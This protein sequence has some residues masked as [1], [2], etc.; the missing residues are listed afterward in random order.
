MI[1][2]ICL[3][4]INRK[5]YLANFNLS[6][7]YFGGGTPSLLTE[8]ELL[9]IIGTIR[10]NYLI[11]DDVE[12]TLESNPDDISDDNLSIWKSVGINRLSIGLQSFRSVD[13]EWMN[14]AHNVEEALVCVEKAQHAG[15]NNLTVDLIY[16]LPNLSLVEWGN[17]VQKVIDMG[18]PHLSAYCLTV[19]DKTALNNWVKKGQIAISSEEAQSEQFLH[20]LAMMEKSGYEQYE[21]S[22]F[23]KT[24]FESRHNSNY[25]KGEWYLGVG[26]S[27]HSFNGF[28]RSWNIANNQL[29]IKT[30]TSQE[31]VY[32]KETLS[33]ED[34]FNEAILT[35][36]RTSYGVK[37][38]RLDW[39]YRQSEDFNE[40]V[41]KFISLQWLLREDD[42]L[43]LTREGKLRADYI[44]SELFIE[45]R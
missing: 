20:L 16:G 23:C 30:I 26:P 4:L 31:T 1:E 18:V 14:R 43:L 15:F 2:S 11:Q 35:G 44:A 36:L 22:N 41:E 27:A 33:R 34:Q 37:L 17:H 13:L 45:S 28:S 24:G 39:E 19:E 12:I 8:D 7:I 10:T 42:L 3:E 25:W 6:T 9:S 21:I 29:Y 32:E 38:A 5:S 40:K